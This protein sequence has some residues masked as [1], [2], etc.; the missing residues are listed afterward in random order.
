M[1]SESV[2][3]DCHY[4]QEQDC[5]VGHFSGDMDIQTAELYLKE[6]VP[7]AQKH[8]SKRFLNDMRNANIKM[9]IVEIY[10]LPS[11]VIRG[12]FDRSWYRAVVVNEKDVELSDFYET[13]A[14]NRGIQVKRFT[15]IEPALH[16]LN[17]RRVSNHTE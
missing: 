1:A 15:A 10:K 14:L 4:D 8:N 17:T 13:V 6:V 7:M 3:A 2:I 9:G 16:W 12:S 11:M 5:L